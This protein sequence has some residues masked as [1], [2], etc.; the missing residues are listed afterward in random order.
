MAELN[1]L[2]GKCISLLFTVPTLFTNF[3]VS[4]QPGI[5]T[6]DQTPN[7]VAIRDGL[8]PY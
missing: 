4:A 2:F 6:T 1:C 7:K 5:Y 3:V 8:V